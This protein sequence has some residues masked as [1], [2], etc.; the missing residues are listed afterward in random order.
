V[1]SVDSFNTIM[2][3]QSLMEFVKTMESTLPSEIRQI[4]FKNQI[5]SSYNQEDGRMI[6]YTSKNSRFNKE[7]KPYLSE[8]NGYVID[9]INM[10]PLVIPIN[11]F[12]SNIN[13]DTVDIY[14]GNGLYD[15]YK[16]EDGTIIN[17]Y[18]WESANKWCI[19]TTRGYDVSD[20]KWGT[21]TYTQILEKLLEFYEI[22]LQTFYDSLNK[23]HCYTFGFKHESMHPF[24]EGKK[25]VINKLWFIQSVELNT[26]E[27]CED[28]KGMYGILNQ[29]KFVDPLCNNI[30]SKYLFSKLSKSLDNFI[31]RNEVCYGF[32]LKS[33]DSS[34]TK[35]YSNILLES[36]LL[37]NIRKLIYHRDLNKYATEMGYNRDLSTIIN[38]YLNPNTCD[39]FITL[40]PQY[41]HVYSDLDIIH[42]KI[43]RSVL[44][45]TMPKL[46]E[47]KLKEDKL[48]ENKLKEDKL[49]EDK[50]KEDK[51]KE[52]KLKEDNSYMKNITEYIYEKI[53]GQ[54]IVDRKNNY[55]DH[56]IS[57]FI[58]T[59]SFIHVFYNMIL[60]TC[61]L[62]EEK[63]SQGIALYIRS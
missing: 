3:Q 26:K 22:N 7:E 50:L 37:Q 21:K 9:T 58:K 27:V 59:T 6:F 1:K 8:C 49:K 16:V 4:A 61:N 52:D 5:Q 54:F 40:F 47:N 32:I 19:S 55:I 57:S 42:D 11:S 20:V 14:M 2:S 17:L 41:K 36:S 38:A 18:W 28:F 12:K 53:N 45:Y 23:E 48:K 30:N 13:P 39:L 24:R 15:I 56:Y 62:S 51:L 60:F 46:K 31:D 43:V 63:N 33:R 44:D 35:S 25:E 29:K 10:K 34:L